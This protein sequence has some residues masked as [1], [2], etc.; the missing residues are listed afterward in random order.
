M[1]HSLNITSIFFYVIIIMDGLTLSVRHL[2]KPLHQI[3][4]KNKN[5]LIIGSTVIFK[6]MLVT[7][8]TSHLCSLNLDKYFVLPINNAVGKVDP[9][10]TSLIM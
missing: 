5:S 6:T 9:N 7:K 1:L 3:M 2:N 4:D 8:V 10:P